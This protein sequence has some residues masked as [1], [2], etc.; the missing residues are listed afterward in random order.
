MRSLSA[1][2]AFTLIELLVVIA[3]T[4]I[5]IALLLPAVQKVRSAANNTHCLNNLRQIGLA[6]HQFHDTRLVFPTAN[7]KE[8]TLVSAFTQI[9]PFLEQEAIARQYDPAKS[10]TDPANIAV[11]QMPIVTYLCPSMQLPPAVQTTAYA[12]YAASIGDNYAW[13]PGPDT[14]ILVRGSFGPI[15]I[16]S[17]TDGTSNTFLVGEM[18]YQLQNYLFTSGPN[19]GQLR[20]GNTSWS[21]GYASYSFASTLVALNTFHHDTSDL[22]KSGL[23]AFRSDHPGGANFLFGDG[24][25]RLIAQSLRLD[26]YRALSTRSGGEV[27]S[28][29]P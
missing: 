23:H 7:N 20:G 22:A 17:I 26:T 10:P 5:L 21:Y 1:R 9:L 12:S 19:A 16:N 18:G 28:D 24:S 14:G 8:G 15:R 11:T 27:I 29:I 25:V 4:A 13:G 6:V 2:S 3:I